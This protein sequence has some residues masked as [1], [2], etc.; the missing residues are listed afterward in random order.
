MFRKSTHASQGA[1]ANEPQSVVRTAST[2]VEASLSPRYPKPKVL[3]ID[4]KD[5]SEAVL[6]GAG[7]NVHGGTLGTPYLV[8]KSSSYQLVPRD[9]KIPNY[10]E[11]EIVVIDLAPNTTLKQAT[12]TVEAVED[13]Y[14][15]W[16]KCNYGLIDPR[17]IASEVFREH[18]D[19]IRTHGGVLTVFADYPVRTNISLARNTGR[20]IEVSGDELELWSFLTTLG[21]DR[22]HIKPSQGKEIQ[23]LDKSIA[24]G[25]LIDRYLKDAHFTCF[26]GPRQYIT[27][28]YSNYNQDYRSW[29]GLA[30][31]KYGYFVAGAF[32]PHDDV[33]G[34]IILLPQIV[35]KSQ[36]IVELLRDVLPDIIPALFPYAE[37]RTWIE[38]D[39]YQVPKVLE[40][41]SQVSAIQAEASEKI[42]Q[43]EREIVI[44]KEQSAYLRQ[45]LTETGDVLVK[46]VKATLEQLGF[47]SVLDM[48]EEN[49]DQDGFKREDLRIMNEPVTLLVEVKGITGLPADT[50][51]L[52]VSKYVVVRMREWKH[53]N[54]QGLAIINHQKGLPPLGREH[55]NTFRQDIL[56]NA[57]EQHFGLMTTWDLFRLARSFGKL[58]WKSEDVKPLF[59]TAGRIRPVPLHYEF[60][61]IVEHFWE[62][63]GAV[64][65]RLQ[66]GELTEG[67]RVAFE[68]PIEFEEQIA[69]SLQ[70]E[71]EQVK[72]ARASELVG[73]KTALSKHQLRNGTRV[74]RVSSNK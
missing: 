55:E 72:I 11:Q 57:E 4:V 43:L 24:L 20:G 45:L 17:P 39:E 34:L 38:K 30:T 73:I 19:M 60:A 1:E 28:S 48:D 8:S 12:R 64:G 71:N 32:T 41:R 58:N 22:F 70:V 33:K 53:T 37:G 67:D 46:A 29:L 59:F 52:Q 23:V 68:W 21:S 63:A 5:D 44:V 6:R 47:A 51:A 9:Y 14:D 65:L 27:G 7:Y 13:N 10:R 49:S 2:N 31:D 36:F 16:G 40:L 50:D 69:Y 54:V 74:F 62:K 56:V 3:L 61:G 35:R 15:Y 66:A 25:K 42:Q 26:F 18:F